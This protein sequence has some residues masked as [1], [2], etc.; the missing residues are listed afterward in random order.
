M[1]AGAVAH[2]LAAG[3]APRDSMTLL[4]VDCSDVEAINVRLFGAL[5][6]EMAAGFE[7]GT[8]PLYK[9]RASKQTKII[10]EILQV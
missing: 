9:W 3:R 10:F 7:K 2:S 4:G 8:M 1:S 6:F 5:L